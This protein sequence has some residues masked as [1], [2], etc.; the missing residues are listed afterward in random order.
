MDN[1]IYSAVYQF[2]LKRSAEVHKLCILNW[3]LKIILTLLTFQKK[4]LKLRLHIPILRVSWI[5]R[6]ISNVFSI[7]TGTNHKLIKTKKIF[8]ILIL[9]ANISVSAQAYQ[10]YSMNFTRV[11]GDLKAL[12]TVQKIYMQK[13]AQNAVDKGDISFWAFLK[14]VRMDN[15]D[16]E[17]RNNYL[18]VLSNSDVDDILS[19][20]NQWWNN[21][22]S[23]LTKKGQ[24]IV[25]ELSS[26]FAWTE[27]SRHISQDKV[28]II[29]GLGT[30]IQFNFASPKNLAGF[31][32]ENKTLLKNYF[33][34]NMSKTG[35]VNWGVGRKIA[36]TGMNTS[37]VSTWDMFDSLES[38]MKYTVGFELPTDISKKSKMN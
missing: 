31:I 15:I 28:S 35:M 29:K 37:S 17:K 21:G 12:E 6:L 10:T 14:S 16:D 19:E 2:M 5:F 23:V 1:S 13:I 3:G 26:K 22:S 20:K 7:F 38:L 25:G 30:H 9:F 4:S 27:D 34:K 24:A 33:S 11:E 18:F 36:P 8:S 32:A